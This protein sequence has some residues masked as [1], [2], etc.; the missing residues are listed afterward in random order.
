M[1]SSENKYV[2]HTVEPFPSL[3]CHIREYLILLIKKNH[4]M[5]EYYIYV[6]TLSLFVL[7]ATIVVSIGRIAKFASLYFK[8]HGLQSNNNV[9]TNFLVGLMIQ[10]GKC[11]QM[12]A[13]C[14]LYQLIINKYFDLLRKRVILSDFVMT[15]VCCLS[16]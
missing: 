9:H 4:T 5:N 16:V 2:W 15:F 6:C 12:S 7:H 3:K 10:S 8:L 1:S 13:N 11:P 14:K